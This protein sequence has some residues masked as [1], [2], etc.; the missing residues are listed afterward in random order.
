MDKD[1]KKKYRYVSCCGKCYCALCDYYKGTIVKAARSLLQFVDR[2]GSLRL[3]A[4]AQKA[5]D[6]DEFTKG[7]RWLSSQQNP[8]KGCRFGGGWSWWGDC[9]VRD[10]CLEKGIDFCYQC[11]EFP[12]KKLREEPLAERKKA[13]IEANRQIRAIGIEAWMLQLKQRY[14]QAATRTAETYIQAST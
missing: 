8:C 14:R 10:C 6:F 5:Y 1:L 12:C 2:Y 13:L 11:E 4:N 9:P 3:I 7:L